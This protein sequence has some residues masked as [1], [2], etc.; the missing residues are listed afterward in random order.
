[1][2]GKRS[3]ESRS[4]DLATQAWWLETYIHIRTYAHL[5]RSMIYDEPRYLQQHPS[6]S[7]FSLAFGRAKSAGGLTSHHLI[8]TAQQE[9]PISPSPRPRFLQA[10]R[11]VRQKVSLAVLVSCA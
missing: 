2:M 3:E 6:V 11:Y 1:M 4:G 7:A 8:I 10:A 9:T 5:Q